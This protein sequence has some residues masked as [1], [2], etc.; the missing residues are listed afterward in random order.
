MSRRFLSSV[1][2]IGITILIL[3]LNTN[4]KVSLNFVIFDISLLKSIAFLFFLG[5]GV[6]IGALL[7]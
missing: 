1:I 5:V 2:L 6:F 3:L 7:R 4:G